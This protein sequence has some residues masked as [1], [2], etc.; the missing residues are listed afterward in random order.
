V[1]ILLG[2]CDE[3]AGIGMR[4]YMKLVRTKISDLCKVTYEFKKA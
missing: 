4:A 2:D 3:K 1:K